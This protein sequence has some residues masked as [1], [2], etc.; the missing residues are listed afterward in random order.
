MAYSTYA[1]WSSSSDPK[2]TTTYTSI[3]NSIRYR[4]EDIARQFNDTDNTPLGTSHVA[5]TIRWDGGNN[6]WV[7]SN[8]SG[9]WADLVASGQYSID[10][11]TVVGCS[12]NNAAGANNLSRNNNTLQN[13]LVS[14][15]LGTNS[16]DAAHFHNA[17]NLSTG[18]IA[19]A[20]LPASI[21]S[22]ITGNA[23]TFTV[24]ANNT[25]NETTYPLFVD[26]TTGTQ[27]AETDSGFTYNP[28]TGNLTSTKFTGSFTGNADT[29]TLLATGRTIAMTGDVV[30]TSTSFNGSANVTAVSAIQANTIGNTEIVNTADIQIASLGVNTAA[31][32]TAGQIRSTGDITAHYS[33]DRLKIRLGNIQNSLNKVVSLNGFNYI[34]NSLANSFGYNTGETFVG[35]SAQEVQK[36]LPEAVKAAPFDINA[37]GAS[38]SG[39]N[40]LTVQYEKIIPL[41]VES[42][43]ELK[44]IVDT[45]QKEINKLKEG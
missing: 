39:E 21:S 30:W 1:D 20:R 10:V 17:S 23:A 42:I 13:T 31:S 27:G 32:G 6:K 38:K 9:T 7:I 3:L 15:Y 19:D 18:T 8:G 16:Q 41:L 14:Q 37:E 45:Q 22:D 4:D 12:A 29:A 34:E 24:S 5:G 11:A 26:G 28:S 44:V 35:V 25:N 43:K 33:D 2:L 40:Y 36:I